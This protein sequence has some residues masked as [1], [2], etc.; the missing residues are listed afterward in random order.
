MK[1]KPCPFCGNEKNRIRKTLKG[2]DAFYIQ[3]PKCGA[4]GGVVYVQKWHDTK[5]IAQGQAAEKWNQRE[6][7]KE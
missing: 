7:E 5:F 6:G 4:R 3:C 2:G 1:L